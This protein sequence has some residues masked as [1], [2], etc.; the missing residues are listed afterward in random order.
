MTK[1]PNRA[2]QS[3]GV[4]P[5]ERTNGNTRR[6]GCPSR[7]GRCGCRPIRFAVARHVSGR[8]SAP[9]VLPASYAH[10]SNTPRSHISMKLLRRRSAQNTTQTAWHTRRPSLI[11]LPRSP[12]WRKSNTQSPN[13]TLLTYCRNR[14]R[15]LKM[16]SVDEGV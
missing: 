8:E 10:H 5:D 16:E 1:V 9:S 13:K 7:T 4:G 3:H 12:D 2:P 15:F 11:S 6:K 14:T